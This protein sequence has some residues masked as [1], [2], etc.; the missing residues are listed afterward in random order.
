M[1]H[2]AGSVMTAAHRV[3][4]KQRVARHRSRLP[5]SL[6]ARHA[7]RR[8]GA[9]VRERLQLVIAQCSADRHIIDRFERRPLTRGHNTLRGL[10]TQAR[11]VLEAETEEQAV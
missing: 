11:D 6:A 5:K 10:G 9:S 8:E 2:I 3:A 4:H 1:A 7:E